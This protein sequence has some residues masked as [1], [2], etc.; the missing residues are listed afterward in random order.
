MLMR[1]LLKGISALDRMLGEDAK[2]SAHSMLA[3][4]LIGTLAH[5]FYGALWTQVTPLEYEGIW[6]RLAGALS[7]F[8]LLINKHWPRS[9]KRFLPWY[10]FGVVLYSLPFF[11]TFQLL[12][13]NYSVL[14]SMLEV[15]MV[16][17][18]VIVFSQPVVALCNLVLG[19]V[20]AAVAAALTLPNFAGLNHDFFFSVHLHLLAYTL[21]AGMIFSRSNLKGQLAQEKLDTVKA[22]TSRIALEMKNPIN[23]IRYRIDLIHQR[24]PHPGISGQSHSVSATDMEVIYR[25]ISKCR[26]SVNWGAQVVE[27]TMDEMGFTPIDTTEFR[28]LSAAAVTRKAVDEFSYQNASDRS[29]VSLTVRD[30]FVF[31]G[32]ETRYVY[33]LFNLLKNATYYFNEHPDARITIVVDDQKV[34]VEDSG[35]GMKPDVLARAFEPFHSVGK[36][37]GTGLGLSFCRRT[38]RALGGKIT[39]ASVTGEFTRF[40]MR[41]PR[42]SSKA[43]ETYEQSLLK[44]AKEVFHGKQILIVDDAPRM[45]ASARDMLGPLGVQVDEAED[46]RMAL[47]MLARKRY[48]AMLLDL[49]M[50]VLDG[51][52]TAETIRRGGVPGLEHMPIV[53][54]SSETQQPAR[55]RLDRIGVDAFIPKGSQPLELIDALCRAHASA[56]RREEALASS[57]TLAGK[58]LLLADDEAFSRKALRAALQERGMKVIEVSDGRTA[59]D[60]LTGA[61]RIDVVLTDIQMPLLDGLGIARAIRALHPPMCNIPVMAMSTHC[62]EAL[63]SAAQEA[64]IDDFLAKPVDLME[65]FQKLNQQLMVVVDPDELSRVL[66]DLRAKLGQL[67]HHV[68][69]NNRGMAQELM[70]AILELAGRINARAFHAELRAQYDFTQE[71]GQWP[72]GDWLPRLRDMFAEVE[73]RFTPP[74]PV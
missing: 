19:V 29:R 26:Q 62:G 68:A 4:G 6:L 35:P 60:L 58:T 14:R 2:R 44:R 51:Y 11:A 42:I 48:D 56:A 23:Q 36:P 66:G 52:D 63:F 38:M 8:G 45:R 46:G 32:D 25:E 50:P 20:L 15:T 49:S 30:D 5:G 9:W 67:V 43:L 64:G 73:R 59:R 7:C 71:K 31:N 18:V 37:V 33:V 27:M 57:S 41:F 17:F 12:G 13:S 47:G 53:I 16:F 72:A 34:I 61:T 55:S 24:L 69:T 10:W 3:V 21:I 39:C 54:Q 65:L 74:V 22:L 1:T 70:C 28:H 40:V